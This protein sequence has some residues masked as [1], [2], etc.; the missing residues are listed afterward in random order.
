MNLLDENVRE[1]QRSQLRTWGLH[2]QQIGSDVGRKG[3]KDEDRIGSWKLATPGKVN[4][5]DL[6][7]AGGVPPGTGPPRRPRLRGTLPPAERARQAKCSRF[8]R[9]SGEGG[10]WRGQTSPSVPAMRAPDRRWASRQKGVRKTTR[11]AGQPPRHGVGWAA[12]GVGAP[13]WGGPDDRESAGPACRQAGD[14]RPPVCR[15]CDA[16]RCRHRQAQSR[17]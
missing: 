9:D 14:R 17:R 11:V 15:G 7:T 16:D 1:D 4:H 8:L 10:C 5:R 2:I 3:M 13:R 12:R 6:A